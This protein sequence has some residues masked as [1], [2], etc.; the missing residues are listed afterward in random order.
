MN[1]TASNQTEYNWDRAG[2]FNG[3]PCRVIEE[4][5]VILDAPGKSTR[6]FVALEEYKALWDA[7]F[8]VHSGPYS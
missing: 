2:E 8:E 7:G 3:I 1:I 6:E 5:H 4:W